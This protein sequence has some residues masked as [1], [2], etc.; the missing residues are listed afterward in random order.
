MKKLLTSLVLALCATFALAQDIVITCVFDGPL[1]GGLPKGV[2]LYCIDE[3][4]LSL[5]GIGGANN[6]GGS[7]SIEYQFPAGVAP[8]GSYLYVSSDS[9]GFADFFGFNA[10]YVTEGTPNAMAI[11]G[12]DAIELFYNGTP[13]CR[14]RA[15]L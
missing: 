9:A 15:N 8:A 10:D 5:L 2:E 11:N 12:D 7:D 4:D 6:G 14:G 13:V 1:S 3:I